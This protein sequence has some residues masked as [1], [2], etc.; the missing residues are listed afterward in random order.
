MKYLYK[1]PQA[2]YPVRRPGRDQPAAGA[3]HEFEYELLDTGVFDEDRYFDVFVEYAKASPEDI[4][5]QITVHN[6]GPEPADAAR[7]ADALV[8]QHLVVGRRRAAAGA[9]AGAGA[10][11]DRGLASGA[12]RALPLL[13]GRR[14]RCS[15]P[16]TRPT[17]ERL[18]GV[19]QPDALRQGRDRQL[20]RPRPRGRG[21]SR[22]RRGRRRRRTIRSPW[23]PGES[24]TIRLRLSRRRR[25]RGERPVRQRLRRRDG[26]APAGGGR[27]LRRRSSRRRSS[28]D[29]AN[30]MRQALAGMLW[31]KQFY[32]YDV[33]KW[34]EERGA[35]PFKAER[36][37]APRNEHWHH[38]YNA[39]I[40][41]MPDKWEYP[42]YAAWDLAFHVL[43]LTLVDED[44]GKQQLDLMLRRALPAPERPDARLRVELRR[45]QP[46]GARLGDDLHLPPGEGAARQG[47]PRVARAHLPQAAAQ[48]HLVGE[49][50][51][52]H[53]Q[54][55]LRGR[56][57]R[58][59]Q[60]RRLR[61]QRA[62]ADRRLPG[63]GGR[64]RL[65]GALLPEHARDRRRAGDRPSRPTST[66]P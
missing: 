50:Q 60:H 17:R 14:R 32:Y 19:A 47:R 43:A 37:A 56:L 54:Q 52:P 58:A 35:D 25:R 41:S 8:P 36:R 27:V 24:R 65:D 42:W 4:L 23:R 57:P 33:D 61:P 53:R 31:S 63:A 30:V 40:I 39:D 10:R 21:E 48:L 45:R 66:W 46:A 29:A 22:A 34:L 6:R 5:I 55:R 7:A 38:M 3:A 49:P 59:R 18:F 44:F 9:P 2:A 28:A 64:H 16:R 62:A 12:R 11:R 15:S 13:R 51:G 20:R 26:G 1:Y